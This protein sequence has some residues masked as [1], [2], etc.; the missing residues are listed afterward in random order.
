MEIGEVLTKTTIFWF[1]LKIC[2]HYLS[3]H[4][5]G[6]AVVVPRLVNGR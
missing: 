1:L 6:R 4:F 2:I 3:Y 5:D